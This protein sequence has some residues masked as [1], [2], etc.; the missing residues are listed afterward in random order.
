MRLILA[1]H[2]Q[3]EW[4]VKRMFRGRIDIPLNE[5]GVRQ[6]NA[7]AKKLSAFKIRKIY[8]SP[9]K[10]ALQTAEAV[11]KRL[12]LKPIPENDLIEINYGKWQGL[13]VDE[14]QKKYRALYAKWLKTPGKTAIPGGETLKRARTR[15]SL[16]LNKILNQYR[17]GDIVIVA[18]EVIIKVILCK[19][20]N[21]SDNF[22]WKL[23]QDTGAIT[24][25]EYHN[26]VS[27]ILSLNDTC[28][29]GSIT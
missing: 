12:N 3:T 27:A 13:A 1:R 17:N 7:V 16:K 5:T 19:L 18:H 23:K 20:L 11:G 26:G 2:G 4:N 24:I 6:A 10:R 22:F 9:L 15:V 14:V 25:L 28:H 29:L 8:S 21:L